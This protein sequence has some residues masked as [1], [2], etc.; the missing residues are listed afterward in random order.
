MLCPNCNSQQDTFCKGNKQTIQLLKKP[1]RTKSQYFEHVRNEYIK[2]QQ[3]YI[4]KVLDSK[5]DF[6]KL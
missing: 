5:I 4:Q 1:K 6:T 2:T 3:K